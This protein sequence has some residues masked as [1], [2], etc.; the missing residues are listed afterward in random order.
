[1]RITRRR[2]DFL[3]KIQQLYEATNLPVHYAQ[4]GKLLGVSKWSAYEMLK[5]LEKEG[6][7]TSQYEVNHGERFP[8]RAM[9][10]FAPTSLADE[11]LSEVASEEKALGMEWR[12]VKDRLL[13]MC[14]TLKGEINSRKL[15]EELLGELPDL[16]RPLIFSAYMIALLIAQLQSL[17]EKG[18]GLLKNVVMGAAK[19]ETG[20]AMF[21]GA[22]MGSMLKT[23]AQFP[24]VSQLVGQMARFQDKLAELNQTEQAVLMDFLAEALEK[25]R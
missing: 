18:I 3:K 16:E 22:A 23:A 19:T 1:M 24:L 7:L 11:V 25:A 5:T 14:E 9:V 8:G 4:V 13:S 20:L 10:L 17:G 6:F 15:V 2:M 21:A 12:Q